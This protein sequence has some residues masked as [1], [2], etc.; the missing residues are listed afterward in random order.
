MSDENMAIEIKQKR[1]KI[2]RYK[3]LNLINKIFIWFNLCVIEHSNSGHRSTSS[4]I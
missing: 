4:V 2:L 1:D 3:T